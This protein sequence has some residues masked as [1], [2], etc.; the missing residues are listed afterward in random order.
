[1]TLG[2]FP[3]DRQSSALCRDTIEDATGLLYRPVLGLAW[4][5]CVDTRLV[6]SK[7]AAGSSGSSS[8]VDGMNIG[9]VSRSATSTGQQ[10]AVGDGVSS[11]GVNSD[12]IVSVDKSAVRARMQAV[13]A[14]TAE[15]ITVGAATIS[16]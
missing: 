5:H 14:I 6:L 15:G 7:R 10:S 11:S 16:T 3:E 1:M 13:Y 12:R 2:S 9:E 4:S 8:G